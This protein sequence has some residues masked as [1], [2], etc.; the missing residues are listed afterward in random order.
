MIAF[1]RILQVQRSAKELLIRRADLSKAFQ[2]FNCTLSRTIRLR[3][4]RT[5]EVQL[6]A[7]RIRKLFELR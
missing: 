1:G 4:L 6:H 3:V 7:D 5:A 2:N